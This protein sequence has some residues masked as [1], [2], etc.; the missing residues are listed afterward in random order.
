MKL[1]KD[2]SEWKLKREK[3]DLPSEGLTHSLWETNDE[4]FGFYFYEICEYGMMKH[5]GKLQILTDKTNPKVMFD[6]D[7]VFFIYNPF[8]NCFT[9]WDWIDKRFVVL[10]Q[11]KDNGYKAPVVLINLD[12][13]KFVSF[14]KFFVTLDLQDNLLTIEETFYNNNSKTER[15]A[16]DKINL[17]TVKWKPL[18]ELT[19]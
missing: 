9:E 1:V 13:L 4:M 7:N 11:L 6:S 18:A 15:K 10:R 12:N 8:G 19:N 16:T 5:C 14:D 17:D 3:I 2:I